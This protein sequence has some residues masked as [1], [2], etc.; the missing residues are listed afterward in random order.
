MSFIL[1]SFKSFTRHIQS[2]SFVILHGLLLS[3]DIQLNPGPI[4]PPLSIYVQL[5]FALFLTLSNI[6]LSLISLIL[7][8]LISLLSLKPG[9]LLMLPLLNFAML[10][11]RASS[12]SAILVLHQPIMHLL[13][14]EAPPFFFGTQLSLL[15]HLPV[16]F[17]TFELSSVTLKLLHSKLT[18]CNVYRPPLATTKTRKSMTFSLFLSVLNP[19]TA[20]RIL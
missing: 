7:A 20:D 15:S 11:P 5:T 18:I 17:K 9:L 3:G 19:R 14:V 2:S 16:T 4:L 8:I 13:L 10:L 6:P 12:F 1:T